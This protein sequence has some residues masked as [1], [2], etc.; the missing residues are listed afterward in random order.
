MRRLNCLILFLVGVVLAVPAQAQWFEL[1]DPDTGTVCGLINAENVRFVISD[2]TAALVL[3]NGNDREFENTVV[4]DAV[5]YIDGEQF[6]GIEFANDSNGRRR[7]FW[8]TNL[9]SLYGLST[10]GEP[11]ATEVFSDEVIGECDPCDSLWDDEDDCLADS[12]DDASTDGTLGAA[13]V[14][15]LCGLGSSSTVAA[16]TVGLLGFTLVRSRRRNL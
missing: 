2:T 14:S 7:V 16:T 3:V 15:S 13:L 1:E 8:L 11:V 4:E 12:T 5:V 10:D 6:G 9:G